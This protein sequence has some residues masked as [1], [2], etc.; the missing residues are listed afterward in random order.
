[1]SQMASEQYPDSCLLDCSAGI[2]SGRPAPVLP[3]AGQALLAGSLAVVIVPPLM[4]APFQVPQIEVGG[5][6]VG[7]TAPHCQSPAVELGSVVI[8]VTNSEGMSGRPAGSAA[9]LQ[10]VCRLPTL[11]PGTAGVG[12][13][14]HAVPSTLVAPSRMACS[15]L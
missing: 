6:G 8:S 9:P 11:Q 14:V 4:V 1:M 5:I 15:S 3:T 13:M 10:P 2:G 7:A 12:S